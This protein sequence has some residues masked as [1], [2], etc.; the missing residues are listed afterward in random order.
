MKW[1]YR[2][3][4]RLEN[5]EHSFAIHEYF[6]KKYGITEDAVAPVSDTLEGLLNEYTS[7]IAEAYAR[8]V[9]EWEDFQ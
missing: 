6:G 1:Q 9:L 4:H 3:V 8:P 7:M 5:G 2:L